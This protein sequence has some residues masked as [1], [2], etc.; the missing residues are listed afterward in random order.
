MAVVNGVFIDNVV[1]KQLPD[2]I[3]DVLKRDKD[4]HILIDGRE[5]SGKSLFAMQMAKAFDP[6][7]NI[8]K[9]AFNADQFIKLVKCPS[10][11]KG[12]CILLDE[13]FSAA[14]ARASLSMINKAM[15]TVATEMRQLNLF[16]I[17]V[18]PTFFDLDKYFAIW[19]CDTLFHVYFD[20]K[21]NRGQYI[22]FPFNDK[23][24]LYIN[25]RKT[26]NYGCWKSPYPPCSFPGAW[27]V[28]ELEYRKRKAQAFRER[29]SET[30]NDRKWKERFFKVVEILHKQNNYTCRE[31]GKFIGVSEDNMQKMLEI[32]ANSHRK[33]EDIS[34]N[35]MV[36]QGSSKY[37]KEHQ[38]ILDEEE[39]DEATA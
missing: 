2:I 17:I 15:I 12:D 23:L 5:G 22:I 25:G 13:A 8:D 35:T 19:R 11:K 24:S 20:G 31:L 39:Q 28:D 30:N 29:K 18:L 3:D 26:Y 27:V 6:N 34:N 9:I 10:R 1:A 38:G 21:G 7:F 16:V 33:I 36:Y 14:S 4:K 32:W 37:T